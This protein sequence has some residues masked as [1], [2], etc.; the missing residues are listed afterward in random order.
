MKELLDLDTLAGVSG[1]AFDKDGNMVAYCRTC[2]KKMTLVRMEKR[3]GITGIFICENERCPE[4]GKE[5]DN[6]QVRL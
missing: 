5:K 2:Q 4:R 3:G 1:G 6:S